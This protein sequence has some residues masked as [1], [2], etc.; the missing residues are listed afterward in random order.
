MGAHVPAL[1]SLPIFIF[2]SAREK[3]W[4]SS[5]KVLEKK[6]EKTKEREKENAAWRLDLVRAAAMAEE[7]RGIREWVDDVLHGLL[8]YSE[9]TLTDYVVAVARRSRSVS[10]LASKLQSQ[11]L[12]QHLASE[13]FSKVKQQNESGPSTSTSEY[14]R[15]EREAAALAE[16]N[17]T[18]YDLV[19]EPN[20]AEE[21]EREKTEREREGERERER[22]SGAAQKA[23]THTAEEVRQGT[24]VHN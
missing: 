11:G 1:P 24:K 6:K 2:F 9:R 7:E 15:S 4:K 18:R 23:Q 16:R 14:R 19:S 22:R 12:P 17:A 3:F 8:G 10:D 13:L 5:G 20:E 21:K